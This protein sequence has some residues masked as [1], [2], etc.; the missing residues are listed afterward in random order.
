MLGVI[1]LAA[2]AGLRMGGVAK[3]LIT[4]EG[5]TLLQRLL[6]SLHRLAP[7]QTVLVLGHHAE[8]IR[9]ALLETPTPLPLTLVHNPE[10]GD[11]PASSLRLGLCALKPE[12]D[13]VILLLADQPLLGANDL[14]RAWQTFIERS[15]VQ[16]ISWP[17]HGGEPGHP[18]LL[19]ADLAREW[20]SQDRAGLRPW[21][22]QRPQQ[23]AVWK[24]NNTHH[25][26]DLDTP[27]ALAR[28]SHDTGQRW[29]LPQAGAKT[30]QT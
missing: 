21:A 16:R 20:L 15:P 19:Q 30:P 3:C 4:V 29:A 1:V 10:P 9:A 5:E 14:Q 27:E 7:V 6:R 26:R 2:G 24:P 18:V 17:E 23:V 13:T 11:S 8:T 22:L 25:T 28:L 12:V